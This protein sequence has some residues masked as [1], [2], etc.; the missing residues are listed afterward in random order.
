MMKRFLW[1]AGII[2]IAACTPETSSAETQTDMAQNDASPAVAT[3]M[4]S[5]PEAAGDD[6]DVTQADETTSTTLISLDG[7]GSFP[8][9]VT[10]GE[11]RT[12]REGLTGLYEANYMVDLSAYCF[13]EGRETLVCG[14]TFYADEPADDE[15]IVFLMTDNHRYRTAENIGPGSTL[16]EAEAIYGEATLSFHYANEGREYVQFANAPDGLMFRPDPVEGDMFAGV[17][18][19]TDGGEYFETNEYGPETTIWLVEVHPPYAE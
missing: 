2:A 3:D 13:E 9:D 12:D 14:F 8:A 15:D 7:I 16:A 6:S 10:M 17:Y 1:A 4:A 18:D 5:A 11:F 19:E